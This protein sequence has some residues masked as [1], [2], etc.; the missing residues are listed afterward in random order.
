L[1]T[2]LVARFMFFV[3]LGALVGMVIAMFTIL[4]LQ[5]MQVDVEG[6]W[7]LVGLILGGLAGGGYAAVTWRG[8]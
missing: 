3:T 7:L 8:A 2:S 5:G 1:K 6:D 4:A